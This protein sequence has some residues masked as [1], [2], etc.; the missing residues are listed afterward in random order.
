[1]SKYDLVDIAGEVQHETEKAYLFFDG[2]RKVWI[3][4]ALCEYDP[5]TKEMTLPEWKA[6]ELELI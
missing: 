1:M 4:K 3:P 5:D 6:M 2:I